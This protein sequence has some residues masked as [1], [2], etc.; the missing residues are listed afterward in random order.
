MFDKNTHQVNQLIALKCTW[1]S[2][3]NYIKLPNNCGLS[4]PSSNLSC[5]PAEITQWN[6]LKGHN[7]AHIFNI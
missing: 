7:I 4:R 3:Q 2:R 5:P 6:D 1:Y